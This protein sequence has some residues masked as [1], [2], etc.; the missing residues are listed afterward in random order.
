MKLTTQDILDDPYFQEF[1]DSSPLKQR[2]KDLY[3][4]FMKNYSNYV[5]KTPTEIIDEAE[6][7]QE[8]GVRSRKR[9]IKKYLNGF[10]RYME[11][12][13]YSPITVRRTIGLNK[14]FYLFFDIDVP[15]I[16]TI[17]HV[18][19]T[20]RDLPTLDEIKKVFRTASTR[21]RALILFHLSSGMGRN[22]V[23]NLK[24]A[25]FLDAIK[26]PSRTPVENVRDFIS[27]KSIPT[28]I[29]KR[30]KVNNYEYVTFISPEATE[31]TVDYLEERKN[32]SEW[33]FANN[34]GKKFPK[35]TYD[36]IFERLN[37]K[38]KLGFKSNGKA[39]RL[40]SHQLRR[41][42]S[43]N[44]LGAG[45]DKNKIDFMMGHRA[46]QIAEAYFK[47]KP[48]ELKKEYIKGLDSITVNR[49]NIVDFESEKVQEMKEEM[50][51]LK[52]KVEMQNKEIQLQKKF[53]T[54]VEKLKKL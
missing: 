7:E 20:I 9:S 3:T 37:D 40:T 19:S 4:L 46:S 12:R 27:E 28:F 36:D 23:T 52:N 48:E 13:K 18:P 45:V 50:N 24:Y 39:R 5:K 44:L 8:D 30:G 25:D 34:D 31:A 53:M 15:K 10:A 6:K 16:R 47:I 21:D 17:P 51:E 2:S 42:F 54:Q 35:R 38:N 14:S 11:K 33:L 41:C 29:I 43:S 49:V 1:L 26:A 22:E 32:E